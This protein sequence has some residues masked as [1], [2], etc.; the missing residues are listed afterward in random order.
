MAKP[1]EISF[2]ISSK[3]TESLINTL[4]DLSGIDKKCTIKIDPENTLLY[5]KVGVGSSINAFKSFVYKTN[6]L[7]E[8]SNF[9]DTINFISS[10][11]KELYRK[12]FILN[13]FKEDNV[14]KFF[15]DELGD[16]FFIDRISL[17]AGNKLKLN[18]IGGDPMALNSKISVD[19]IKETMDIDNSNFSF[20]LRSDD[21]LNIKKLSTT[22]IENDIFYLNTVNKEDGN[23]YVSIGESAWDLIL[24]EIDYKKQMTLSFPKKYFK[25]ISISG[26]S[27]K[28][29]VFDNML[30]VSDDNSDMLISTEMSS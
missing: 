30:M 14:G 22:E 21:F 5:S 1:K 12:L 8:I 11:S 19:I 28:V 25:N 23:Y 9:E 7:F 17:K 18:F 6:D 10:D 13:S 24:S 3:N 26:E 20:N 16:N 27:V 29:Y 15:Y 2:R 4:R